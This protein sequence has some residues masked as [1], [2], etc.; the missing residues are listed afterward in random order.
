MLSAFVL[1]LNIHLKHILMKHIFFCDT[2]WFYI[3]TAYV[4]T[5]RCYFQISLTFYGPRMLPCGTP[6]ECICFN[7]KNKCTL[8]YIF[9]TLWF[10]I[11][12]V[13]VWSGMLFSR[14]FNLLSK[15][16]MRFSLRRRCHTNKSPFI[17]SLSVVVNTRIVRKTPSA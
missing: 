4:L 7:L 12:T 2:N 15:S 5:V 6:V 13:Y 16:A 8:K 1:I 9:N 3:N 17:G 11:N 14:L 10:C